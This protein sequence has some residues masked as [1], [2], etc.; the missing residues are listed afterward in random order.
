MSLDI[1]VVFESRESMKR[2][3]DSMLILPPASFNKRDEV[4]HHPDGTRVQYMVIANEADL[5]RIQGMRFQHIELM[6]QPSEQIYNYMKVL[7]RHPHQ[8]N[9]PSKEDGIDER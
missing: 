8:A 9:Q 6:Y 1:L 2:H 3:I 5:L 4:L 7:M